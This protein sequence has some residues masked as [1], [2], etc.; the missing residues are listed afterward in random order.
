MNTATTSVHQQ[1][2]VYEVIGI[3]YNY[4]L[5]FLHDYVT[6]IGFCEKS[7]LKIY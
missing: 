7:I 1:L 5:K 2:S 6:S 4:G 3:F